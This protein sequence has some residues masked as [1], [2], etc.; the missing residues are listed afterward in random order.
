MS[1]VLH[2]QTQEQGRS[3]PISPHTLSQAL[4]FPLE[5]WVQAPRLPA[6]RG[7][8]FRG[9]PSGRNQSRK[10]SSCSAMF[11]DTVN[12]FPFRNLSQMQ[13]HLSYP[14]TLHLETLNKIWTQAP[15]TWLHHT[16]LVGRHAPPRTRDN[17]PLYLLVY[18][19]CVVYQS[20]LNVFR[21]RSRRD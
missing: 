17:T 2:L 13:K 19:F 16:G 9:L 8:M 18:L 14:S 3:P 11:E 4:R 15:L 1:G 20:K 12:N 6:H 21:C 7:L 10:A 5:C